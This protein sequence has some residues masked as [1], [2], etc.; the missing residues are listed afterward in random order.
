[1][2]TCLADAGLDWQA[3]GYDNGLDYQDSCDAWAWQLR[4]LEGAAEAPGKTDATCS[5]RADLIEDTDC[6]AFFELSWT[7]PDWAT[8]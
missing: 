6:D 5:A 8:Q 2:D 3:A 7:T 4:E 1:M